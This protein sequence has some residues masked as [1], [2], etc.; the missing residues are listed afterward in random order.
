MPDP[1]ADI[2]VVAP[3]GDLDLATSRDLASRLGELA[4]TQGDA[5]LDLTEVGFIDSIGLAVVLKA[6]NRFSRQDKQLVLVVP[7]EGNVSRLLEMSGV[8]GRVSRAETREDALA[9][10]TRPG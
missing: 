1:A 8:G 3:A 7:P 9:R 10:A 2:P 5:V 6:A 4:G